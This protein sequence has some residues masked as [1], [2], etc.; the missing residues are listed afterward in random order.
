MLTP[1]TDYQAPII[2]NDS[3]SFHTSWGMPSEAQ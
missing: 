1:E 3:M 2:A